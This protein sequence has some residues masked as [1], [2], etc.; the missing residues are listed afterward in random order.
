MTCKTNLLSG[1]LLYI[2]NCFFFTFTQSNI[3][4][5][6]IFDD[7]KHDLLLNYI[8]SDGQKLAMPFHVTRSINLD[9]GWLPSHWL[10]QSPVWL[11]P[12]SELRKVL[13]CREEQ[14]SYF[15]FPEPFIKKK[16]LF[17]LLQNNIYHCMGCHSKHS[18]MLH[19]LELKNFK[20]S[21][22][23]RKY[24][25]K[26]QEACSTPFVFLGKSFWFWKNAPHL[27]QL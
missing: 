14:K 6:V 20:W 17:Q 3:S 26:L 4:I 22:L 18:T 23:Q 11:Q 15:P 27:S 7:K 8:T 16:Q 13:R 25:L 1:P 10:L 19:D 2:R 9:T 24:C 5:M 21:Y 12:T